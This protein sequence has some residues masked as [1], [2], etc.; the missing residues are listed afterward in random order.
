MSGEHS[1]S[2]EERHLGVIGDGAQF[3]IR[4]GVVADSLFAVGYYNFVE[5]QEF[6]GRAKGIAHRA[7]KQAT[8]EM[9][10]QL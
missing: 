8:A 10:A 1:L 3:S 4:G 7:A 6:D 2:G 5:V 9:A